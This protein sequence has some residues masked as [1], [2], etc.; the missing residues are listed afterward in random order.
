[1]LQHGAEFEN[2]Y[3]LVIA[4]GDIPANTWIRYCMQ[5]ATWFD[6]PPE[7]SKFLAVLKSSAGDMT[8]RDQPLK[9]PFIARLNNN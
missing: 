4:A 5:C 1:M 8:E 3:S 2:A 7:E 9:T 6:D